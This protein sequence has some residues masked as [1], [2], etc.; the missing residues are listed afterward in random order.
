[1][2]GIINLETNNLQSLINAFNSIGVNNI[3]VDNS[4]DIRKAK[5]LVL[6]GVGSFESGMNS[7]KK[8]MVLMI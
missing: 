4:D 6:P 8:K 1:M 3:I 2:I 5:A 7:L